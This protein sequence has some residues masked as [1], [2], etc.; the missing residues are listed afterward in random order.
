MAGIPIVRGEY[1]RHSISAG[2]KAG[3]AGYVLKDIGKGEPVTAI[4]RL[5]W[6]LEHR[7]PTD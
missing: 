1:N 6:C 3:I 2:I 4:R 7:L 5:W